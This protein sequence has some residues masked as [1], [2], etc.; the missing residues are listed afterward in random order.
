MDVF[1]TE[2]SAATAIASLITALSRRREVAV[3]LAAR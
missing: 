3:P 1:S 2:K